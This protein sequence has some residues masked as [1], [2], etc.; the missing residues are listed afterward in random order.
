MKATIRL[1]SKAFLLILLFSAGFLIAGGLFPALRLIRSPIKAR[2]LRDA[3]KVRWLHGFSRILN[4]R[5]DMNGGVAPGPA[6]IV[7]NHVSW[8]DIIVLGRIVPGCFAAKDDIAGWPVIGYLSRQ[9]GTVFIRR[10][11]RKQILQT[12][13]T[14][15]WQLRRGGNMLVFPE[16]T[17]T[18]GSEV[19]DFHASLF[20]PALL[21]KA[22]IQPAA[23]RYA[24]AAKG[25]APF[26]G[27]DE[28]VPH[29]LRM[30]ALEEIEVRLDFLPAIECGQKTRIGIGRE[31]RSLI[32]DTLRSGDPTT[33]SAPLSRKVR[34]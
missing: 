19:L 22:A 6:L 20:Q 16:G 5:I 10:G 4:L 27:D 29:L 26:V 32:Q 8:L 23:I 7:S 24:N 21:A 9:A 31:A 17:T 1:Y 34:R 18:D 28:F 13:E 33:G 3:I 30:L 2:Q 14:M 12:A 25:P 15:A 11:D